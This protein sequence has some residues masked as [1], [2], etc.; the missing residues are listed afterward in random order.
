MILVV[1]V[2]FMV[3]EDYGLTLDDESY[4]LNGVFY[5]EF[6]QNY[7][8]SIFS[9]DFSELS[10][11]NEEIQNTPIR[12]HPA[13]FEIFLE[14]IVK[15]FGVTE[16]NEIYNI[17]HL[18]NYLIFSF[19]LF[20]CYKI[21]SVR[22]NSNLLSIL[23]IFLIF[24]TPRFFAE[25]FYNSRDIFFFS[26]FIFFIYTVQCQLDRDDHK[27]K[28]LVSLTSAL[29][30]SSKVLG[31]I[32]FLIYILFYSIHNSEKNKNLLKIL[33]KVIL[34]IFLTLLF[35][36]ILW[37]Y[38]WLNPIENLIEGYFG[39]LKDHDNLKV[40]T[41]FMGEQQTS[42]STPWYFRIVWFYITTPLIICLLFSSGL[43]ALVTKFI[44]CIM[45]L[46]E[47]DSNLIINKSNFLD[48]FLL[49]NLILIVFVTAKYN[50]SQ[51]NGWRHLYFLYL[52]IIYISIFAIRELAMNKRVKV[53]VFFIL[54]ISC[55]LNAL[56]IFKNHP[57][58]NNYLNYLASKYAINKFDL[59][60]WGL[61]NY[62]SLKYILDKDNR[63]LIN[64]S[65]VSF[66]NLN[67]SKL[68][69]DKKNRERLNVVFD[70]SKADY[71]INSYMSRLGENY[72]HNFKDY[73]KF[74]EITVLGKPINTVYKKN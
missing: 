58:Q 28:I 16:I 6:I 55:A 18:L 19:S 25:S 45:N 20:I 23:S 36:L 40:L 17:S 33:T 8:L 24:F 54:T 10:N 57:Y 51:F 73:E 44:R 4:R 15:I 39:I 56:W 27:N 3:Y 47:K 34:I 62:Q 63:K 60:Y 65:T 35:A 59:D 7:F 49:L 64:V 42:T 52:P 67:I 48:F 69:L 5:K 70:Y 12:N 72:K 26:L 13:I 53:V 50:D 66:A 31:I 2:G 1:V 11:L 21:I 46:N 68:K 9:F 32:P 30:I 14:F 29:L 41:L 22:F 38:L 74:Y 71:L 43:V 37:P 61:S